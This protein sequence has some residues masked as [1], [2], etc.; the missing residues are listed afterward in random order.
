MTV[1]FF[2]TSPWLSA[3]LDAADDGAEGPAA[4]IATAELPVRVAD[5]ESLTVVAVYFAYHGSYLTYVST[6][7]SCIGPDI[8]PARCHAA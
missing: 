8:G 1:S 5:P 2:A 6:S 3:I 7:S 4:R